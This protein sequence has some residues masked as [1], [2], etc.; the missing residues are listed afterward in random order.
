VPKEVPEDDFDIAVA[1]ALRGSVDVA[2]FPPSAAWDLARPIRFDADWRGENTD[3]E[4]A[5]E[6]RLL[7]TPATLYLKFVAR[8]RVL[9]VFP[10]ADA[11]GRRDKLWDRD[12]VEVFLQP[13]SSILRQYK[14]FEVSPNGFWIDLDIA[15]GLLADL[16]SGMQR[17]VTVDEHSKTWTAE[18]AIPMK[19][20]SQHF[21]AH[22][23]WR[24]NFYRIEGASEPRFYAAWRPTKTPRPNFHVPE[25]FGHLKFAPAKP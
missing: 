19:S 24:A 14:E 13:D 12:V 18:L 7:W 1:A 21:D 25:L 10:D 2:G 22:A 8:Y 4:R 5:T 23:V 17:R 6:V 3:P 11:N 15:N 16:K 20:L 9:T